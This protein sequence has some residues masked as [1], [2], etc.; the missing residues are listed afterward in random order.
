MS[1]VREGE[2]EAEASVDSAGVQVIELYRVPSPMEVLA[3]K[4]RELLF[5]AEGEP[6]SLAVALHSSTFGEGRNLTRSQRDV[7]AEAMVAAGWFKGRFEVAWYGIVAQSQHEP[8]GLALAG[9]RSSRR[10]T[11]R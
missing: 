9:S 4:E 6:K 8:R 3:G 7:A 11:A 2:C 5:R 10:Y 1:V